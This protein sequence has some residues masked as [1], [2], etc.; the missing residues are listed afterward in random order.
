MTSPSATAEALLAAQR[1]PEAFSRHPQWPALVD[2]ARQ[3][4]AA[5]GDLPRWSNALMSL[6]DLSPRTLT[7]AD[8]VGAD[9]PASSA[10]RQ[11]LR[12]ALANLHPWRKGPFELFGVHIDTEWRSDWKW[13]RIAAALGPLPGAEILDV[14]CGNGYFGWRA[15]SVGAARVLGV[16]PSVLFYLQHLAVSKYVA[17][18]APGH[19]VLLPIPF[20]ILPVQSFDLVLSMGVIY[21]RPH[22]A[23]HIRQ[24]A[25]QVAPG[26]RLLLESLVVTSGPD[27]Y[28]AHNERYARMRNVSVV[29]RVDSLTQWLHDAG[30]GSVEVIDVSRTTANEQRSTPWMTFESLA[31]A[32]DPGDPERTVEGH[33]APVRAAL[34]A[35]R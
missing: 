7:L 24:L 18:L 33:P 27:L 1:V 34:L 31:E 11:R 12:E 28:P 29:P 10:E 16:D 13:R 23:E 22:P 21:H 17:P 25:A 2:A 30:F 8:R 32:L 14:G 15:L 26:G 35:K 5:H 9:G 20:E 19:N 6:P 3:R 4:L